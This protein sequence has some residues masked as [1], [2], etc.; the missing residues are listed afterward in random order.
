[1]NSRPW[2]EVFIDGKSYGP[3]P[4]L[5]I[6]LPTGKHSLRLVN[7]EF[8]VEKT[9]E[10]VIFAGETQSVIVNLLEN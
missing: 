7:A 6:D 2:A 5:N 3:T 1:V 4:R 8:K 9:V 10:F